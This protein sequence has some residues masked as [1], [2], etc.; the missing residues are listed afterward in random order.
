MSRDCRHLLQSTYCVQVPQP[1]AHGVTD[2]ALPWARPDTFVPCVLDTWRVR[3]PEPAIGPREGHASLFQGRLQL[4]QSCAMV[5]GGKLTADRRRRNLT[6][7]LA[8]HLCLCPAHLGVPLSCVRGY[9]LAD[10]SAT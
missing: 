3:S 6:V 10:T 1:P 8:L 2:I 4:C 9:P 7:L 5:D